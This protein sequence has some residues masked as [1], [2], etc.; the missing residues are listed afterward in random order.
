[1]LGE[2]GIHE[3]LHFTILNCSTRDKTMGWW[4]Y[5][6]RRHCNE[7]SHSKLDI[8]EFSLVMFVSIFGHLKNIY[9]IKIIYRLLKV[10]NFIYK[11]VDQSLVVCF[12]F[13]VWYSRLFR[14]CI[15]VPNK[16]IN[17]YY[18]IIFLFFYATKGD[19]LRLNVVFTVFIYHRYPY[20]FFPCSIQI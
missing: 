12:P 18:Y 20:L 19:Y 6:L 17:N 15:F 14:V 8:Q 16:Y 9:Y 10:N 2:G 3:Y 13:L 5:E 1:M 11:L 7:F 4:A